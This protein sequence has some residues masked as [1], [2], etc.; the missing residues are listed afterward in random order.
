LPSGGSATSR[1]SSGKYGKLTLTG[2]AVG[3]SI[4]DSGNRESSEGSCPGGEKDAK[5]REYIQDGQ[6]S[7]CSF[8][9]LSYV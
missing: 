9:E 5:E 4:E 7:F 1:P 2:G 6:R 3:L 8:F